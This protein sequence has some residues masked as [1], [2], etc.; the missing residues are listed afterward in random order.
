[1]NTQPLNAVSGTELAVCLDIQQR[2]QHGIAKY[3]VTVADNPLALREW[4]QHAYEEM[5][6]GAIYLKRALEKLDA[7]MEQ[8]AAERQNIEIVRDAL[9]AALPESMPVERVAAATL[10]RVADW[11]PLKT[12]G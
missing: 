3:T 4:L 6:D 9:L 8:I 10:P 1:M 12:K 7:E 11:P 2:Q 5:L